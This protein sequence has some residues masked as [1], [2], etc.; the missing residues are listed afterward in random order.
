MNHS[1]VYYSVGALLYCPANNSSV[2]SSVIS[3]GFG[4]KY[5]LALCLEDTINDSHVAQA[6]SQ[7]LCSLS[8]I[9]GEAQSKDF[10][11]PK[12][13]IRVRNTSQIERLVCLAGSSASIIT[14]FILPKFSLEN[15][16]GYIN[17]ISKLNANTTQYYMMP[18]F[19]NPCIVNL[20]E[21]RQILYSLKEKLD[22]VSESVLNI[23]VG[24]NDLCNVFGLRRH[25]NE[26]IYDIK[27]VA[28]ILSDIVTVFGPEYIVSGPIWEYYSGE[29]WDTGM[30]HEIAKDKAFGFIGKTVIHPKQIEIVN[31]CYAVTAEDYQD[32]LSILDWDEKN[33]KLVSGSTARERMNEYKTHYRWAIRTKFLADFYG[34]V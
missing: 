25:R 32:A 26:T 2:A 6:E 23:R 18:I 28:D 16:D 21:R 17:A 27:P 30:R 12:L 11:M 13:F 10:Y 7:L 3:G 33:P 24:G 15:A 1:M 29:N 34:V 9:V 8:H 19:E 5:S 22:P 20:Q 31:Q 14:G 4:S